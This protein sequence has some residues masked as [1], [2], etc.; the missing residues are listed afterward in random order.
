MKLIKFIVIVPI[1]I[2][3]FACN[4]KQGKK[5]GA[6]KITSDKSNTRQSELTPLEN[7]VQKI[8]T[9]S[10]RYKKLTAGLCEAVVKN[11]GLSIGV[12]LEGSPIQKE[13]SDWVFS[14]TFDFTLFEMYPDRKLNTIRFSFDPENKQLYEFDAANDQLKPIEFDRSL[15]IEY[16]ILCK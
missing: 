5:D 10:P 8:L 11:G 7:V 13:H 3:A 14:K 15:L 1:L 12:N 4:S 16:D 2:V 6:N 9:T